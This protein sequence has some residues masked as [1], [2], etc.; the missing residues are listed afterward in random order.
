MKPI[1]TETTNAVYTCEGCEDLPVTKYINMNN[2]E[3]GVE[4]VWELTPEEIEQVKET[5]RIY[6]YMQGEVVPPVFLTT[7]SVVVFLDE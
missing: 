3:E 1:R 7:E 4:S 2:N 5:G 6:L